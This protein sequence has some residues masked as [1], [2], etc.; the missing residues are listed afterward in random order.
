MYRSQEA[1]TAQRQSPSGEVPLQK[2]CSAGGA[3]SSRL[4]LAP[5]MRMKGD[6]RLNP[7]EEG[8]LRRHRK[9]L[10]DPGPR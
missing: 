3:K 2:Y 6:L 4:M 10:V 7:R 1:S 9:I 5:V 8:T